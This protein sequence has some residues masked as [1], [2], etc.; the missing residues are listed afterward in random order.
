MPLPVPTLD[1][2]HFQDIVDQA[3]LLIPHYCPEWT[4]HNVSDPGV[5]LIELFAWMTDMLLYRVNQ[6]PDK[7]Y[8]KFL[9][10]IGVQLEEPRA[11]TAPITFYLSA[12]QP[13]D[14]VIP[15]DTEVGTVRTETSPSIIFT[16]EKDLTIRPPK[17]IDTF[18]RNASKRDVWLRH[19]LSQ[20]EL[21]NRRTL[22]FPQNPS[23]GDSFLLAFQQDHSNHILALLVNCDRAGGAGVDP[24][25]PPLEW[26]VWQGGAARWTACELEYDGTGGFNEPGEIILHLPEMAQAEFQGLKAYWLRCRLTDAQA[27]PRNYKVSPALIRLRVESRGGTVSA[28][29][30][31]SVHNEYLGTSDGTPGQVFKLLHSPILALDPRRDTLIVTPPAGM[32]RPQRWQEVADFADSGPEDHHYT[33]D[34]LDGT[35]T[36]GPSL[37]QPDGFVYRF[38]SVP[39]KGSEL[40]FSRYQY[41]GGVIG[42]V[43]QGT[44]TVLKSSIPYV[45]H[46]TNRLPA[47][48]G[49]DAQSLEDAKLRAPRKL[50][51]RT[52]A[53]TA[54]DHEHLA[55]EVSGVARARCLAPGAQPGAPGDPRPGQVFVIVLPQIDETEGYIPAARL[56]LSAELRAAVLGQLEQRRL[57]GTALEVRQPQYVWVTVQAEL[58]VAERSDPALIEEVQRRAEERLYRYL[59]PY[60]GGPRGDGWP[61]GRSLNRSE[62]FGVLQQIPDIEYVEDVQIRVSE[63]PDAVNPQ[64]AALRTVTVPRHGLI[65]SNRH[66]VKVR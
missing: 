65:C 40:S 41:G 11:A 24:R 25:N 57:L 6:V 2:R 42:N 26:Q 53:V 58:R 10:M 45:A 54:D 38:G 21:L 4:D 9:Q 66:Q 27:G 52:R 44:L 51:T 59:N 29:H 23:P 32:G 48:G 8:I 43:A 36:L 28:R 30:A 49:R 20:A 34:K 16:T 55:R 62:I 15:A 46:V 33:L 31:V 14:V 22:M 3:K 37:L 61:F 35:L 17:L 5:T 63:T 1:D 64:A 60:T 47:M 39:E 12:A 19:N 50:R 13:A 56:T 18:T 7:N